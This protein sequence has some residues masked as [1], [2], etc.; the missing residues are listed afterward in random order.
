MCNDYGNRVPYSAY[1]EAF[2]HLKI[3]LRLA[4]PRTW[5]RGTTSGRQTLLPLFARMKAVPNSFSCAG[6][7]RLV[8]RR[9]HR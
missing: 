6:D 1:L 5:N 2:S 8:D 9:A 7:S 3:P 4:G